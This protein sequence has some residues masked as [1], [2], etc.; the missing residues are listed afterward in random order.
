VAFCWFTSY[1]GYSDFFASSGNSAELARSFHTLARAAGK[2]ATYGDSKK[3]FPGLDHAQ[4]ETKKAAFQEFGLLYVVPRSDRISVTPL[5]KQITS[6]TFNQ[7]R[8]DQNRR[9]VLF[10]LARG[11]AR[12]QFDNP[13]PVGGAK[14]IARAQSS[15]VR[16]YL[17]C[18]YLLQ[19]LDGFITTS[20][21]F[22][23]ISALQKSKDVVS[24]VD[25]IRVAR[26]SHS[27]L[28]PHAGLPTVKGT[29][30]NLKIYFFAHLGLANHILRSKQGDTTVYSTPDQVFELTETGYEITASVL[31]SEWPSWRIGK[32][33]APTSAS[34]ISISD[35][36]SNG[37]GNACPAG[38]MAHDIKVAE[39]KSER[40]GEG[41]IDADTLA[42]LKELPH[43]EYE[44]GKTRLVQHTKLERSRNPKLVRDAKKAFKRDHGSLSCEICKFD[45][46]K[47][48]GMR[49]QDFIEAHHRKP[50]SK[51]DGGEAVKLTIKDLAM[52]CSNC[53]R[54]LHRVPWLSVEELKKL[55]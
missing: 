48:Y 40:T 44:D 45:F 22:G 42:S 55:I 49:G 19:K 26:K 28:V 17:V 30:D 16:P 12:Y 37:V 52:V 24:V 7:K 38:L 8:A 9:V 54:M 4:V 18:Y 53:H 21:F 27:K 20:E 6:W 11:L 43:R 35:Y 25:Q 15:D 47:R 32:V 13:L 31:D 3:L 23:A 5:G 41:L 1:I 2:G 50:I 10:A 51:I 33:K 14:G 34:F 39:E 36:F 46:E 29:T